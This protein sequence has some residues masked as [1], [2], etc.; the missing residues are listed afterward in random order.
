MLPCLPRALPAPLMS[1][2]GRGQKP[3]KEG[4]GRNDLNF[5]CPGVGFTKVGGRCARFW[6][7]A[8]MFH[9]KCLIVDNFSIISCAK[10]STSVSDSSISLRFLSI[11]LIL[12]FTPLFFFFSFVY[13]REKRNK[14]IHR[15]KAQSIN[16][17]KSIFDHPS[18]GFRN[19]ANWWMKT[20]KK[21]IKNSVLALLPSIST[22]PPVFSLSPR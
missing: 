1:R 21:L 4:L 10:T 12:R 13:K 9:A 14:G 6:W 3:G 2:V 15:K 22:N 5:F 18:V 7:I 17:P 11:S 20:D 19:F 16:F 8:P